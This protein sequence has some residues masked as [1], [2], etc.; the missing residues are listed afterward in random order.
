MKRELPELEKENTLGKMLTDGMTQEEVAKALQIS[1]SQ[2][3]TIEKK[4]LLKVKNK[5]NRLY[6]KEDLI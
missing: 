2:V 1:R 6:K 4:T 5:L 3:G